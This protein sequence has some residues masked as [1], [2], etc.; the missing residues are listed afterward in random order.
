ML[1][2]IRIMFIGDQVVCGTMLSS[3]I[4]FADGMDVISRFGTAKAALGILKQSGAESH[5]DIV[6]LD[7]HLP[8]ISGCEAMLR[9]RKYAPGA[10]IIVLC[11]SNSST[12]VNEAI[13]QGAAGYLM[14]SATHAQ[15]VQSI[16]D[17]LA[18]G[19][20]LDPEVGKYMIDMIQLRGSK[21]QLSQPL[22][23]RETEI[24][25]LM[26]DGLVRR[27]I[28]GLLTVST[29]TVETHVRSILEKL[30]AVNV[31]AAVH[32]AFCLGL[33]SV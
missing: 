17:V 3:A 13:R 28:A 21:D 30:D 27:E 20:S 6:L 18:G 1:R 29:H 32:K 19:V 4:G 23:R 14:K 31:A 15:V 2:N 16:R 8:D 26:A 11:R 10:K 12:D 22:S 33:L 9:I 25:K 7:L 24:L 5:P